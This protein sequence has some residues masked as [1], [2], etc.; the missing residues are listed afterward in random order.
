MSHVVDH[1]GTAEQTG[2]LQQAA[3][4][5]LL[6]GR[7]LIAG[8]LNGHLH[9][10]TVGRNGHAA[11]GIAAADGLP[12]HQRLPLGGHQCWRLTGFFNVDGNVVVGRIAVARSAYALCH[13]LAAVEAGATDDCAGAR[14]QGAAVAVFLDG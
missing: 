11:G 14:S 13:A 9:A 7:A 10:A 4:G 3:L 2:V 1:V 5:D 8:G 12:G 6:Q